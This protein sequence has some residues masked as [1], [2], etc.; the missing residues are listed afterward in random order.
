[1]LVDM[2][3]TGLAIGCVYGLVAIGYSLIFRAQGLINFAQG[4]MLTIGALVGYT[5]IVSLKI[6]YFLGVLVSVVVGGLVAVGIETLIYAPI[7]RKEAVTSA[8][9]VFATIAMM[10]I[11]ANGAKAIWGSD[12]LTYPEQGSIIQLG[13]VGIASYY[14]LVMGVTAVAVIALTIILFKTKVGLAMRAF[15]AD[16]VTASLMGILGKRVSNMTSFL[17]G[18]VGAVGGVLLAQIYFASF[19]LG[20]F[21]M[22]AFAAAILGG[23][24]S[25]PGAMV[26]G[27]ILG[28][29]ETA[30]S[31]T[32]SAA[33]KDAMV[34]GMLIAV[35]L[36]KPTGIFKG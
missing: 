28:V 33:Y 36:F 6:P 14:F 3:T 30:V 7:R 18:G 17:A 23:L 21:G 1:M 10:I 31:I 26:G 13:T 29:F 24:G 27:L 22:K 35:L 16:A 9:S 5:A 19:E 4:E 12:A 8:R 15:A 20:G 25:V 2:L 11:L 32:I 34:Y